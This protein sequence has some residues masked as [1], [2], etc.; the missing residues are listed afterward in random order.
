M[1][2]ANPKARVVIVV[3]AMIV[4]A[5]VFV[6]SNVDI[7][8]VNRIIRPTEIGIGT[9]CAR[10]DVD[11]CRDLC[12]AL[13]D[14]SRLRCNVATFAAPTGTEGGGGPRARLEIR[15]GQGSSRG[16]SAPSTSSVPS[17]S[18]PPT[19]GGGP[20]P[21]PSPAPSPAPAPSP[22]PD[23]APAPDP[24]SPPPRRGPVGRTIDRVQDAVCP[25]V[26]PMVRREPVCPP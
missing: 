16:A 19:S 20:S 6:A 7:P 5:V 10:G 15:P 11:A 22:D 8:G 21:S 2:R 18:L 17:P 1:S 14:V 26:P 23:P 9:Q 25:H 3:V 12:D 4:L 24:P 13:A